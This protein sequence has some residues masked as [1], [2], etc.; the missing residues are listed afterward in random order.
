MPCCHTSL[1]PPLIKGLGAGE[2][3]GRVG[4]KVACGSLAPHPASSVMMGRARHLIGN[5]SAQGFLTP[6]TALIWSPGASSYIWSSVPTC[7][8]Y[9]KPPRAARRSFTPFNVLC[10]PKK[11]GRESQ[12]QDWGGFLD[13]CCRCFLESKSLHPQKKVMLRMRRSKK[14]PGQNW[15]L[16]LG[17][18]ATGELWSLHLVFQALFKLR[19]QIPMY[20]I[21][22][23]Q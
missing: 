4:L 21:L 19:V 11:E 14:C 12:K 23:P 15:F 5:C 7:I 6:Q 10:T 9:A 2:H 3:Q 17:T 1:A 13:C 22:R 20:E 16:G 8:T 18:R